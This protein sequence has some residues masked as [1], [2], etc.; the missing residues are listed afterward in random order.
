[1]PSSEPQRLWSPRPADLSASRLSDFA[2]FVHA[3]TGVDYGTDYHAL[4]TWTVDDQSGFWSAVWD[5][6]GIPRR[7]PSGPVLTGDAMPRTT[8]FPGETINFTAEVFRNRPADGVAVVSVSEDQ[9]PVD[10]T[11][12]QL[13]QRVASTAAYLR[14]LGVREGDRVV[15]YLTNDV[16][17]VIAFL[18]TASTGA[19][20][21]LCGLDYAPSAAAARLG[22]L[23]PVVAIVGTHHTYRGVRRDMSDR[24]RALIDGLPGSPRIIEVGGDGVLADAVSWSDVIADRGASLSPL[25]VDFSHPLWVLF[26]SGTTGKPKGIVHGHGGVVLEHLKLNALQLDLAEKDRMLWYTTPSWMM[27]NAL[28]GCLLTGASIVCFDGNPSYPGPD[29]LWVAA[30]TTE[31]TLLGTSPA[32]LTACR[33]ADVA[34]DRHRLSNLR[35]VGVTGSAFP[36]E[37]AEW[38]AERLPDG[39]QIASTSG[40]TDVV[41]AFAGPSPW[42]P[43][44]AGELSGPCLGVALDTFDVTGAPV[45]D[46]VGE[47]VVTKPLPSMPLRFWNDPTGERLFEAYFSTF[48]G[49]WRHGDWT[50]ITDRG[51]VILHG[52]SDATLNRH[53]I[54]IGTAD[55]YDVVESLSFIDEA[56]VIGVEEPGG[57]YWMP[58]FVTTADDG[59]LDDRQRKTIVTQISRRASS[60]HVPDEIIQVPAIPHTR[61]GKKLEVPI[62]RIL[63]GEDPRAVV[64]LDSVD[65]P[66]A[67]AA[68]H[69]LGRS[70]AGQRVAL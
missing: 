46:V 56:L 70:R 43:V 69:S 27:W 36:A 47:L 17:T 21:A 42:R 2:R 30:A 29:S 39:V 31:A 3:R 20:W 14:D 61:T 64:E 59:I 26:S 7:D 15:G 19:I 41:T 8:W 50:T 44:W 66:E 49:V 55:I 12:G 24:A 18:A 32:Y 57:G 58:M 52:R 25:A 48:P 23:D 45:R 11:W 22:Q 34:L 9:P 67:L 51:S 62:K 54:R 63:G 37:L 65:A 13:E 28:V 16:E 5:Y 4:W 10:V 6:F 68:F 1:M 60:R 40:G 35:R 53:G 33:A 38:L